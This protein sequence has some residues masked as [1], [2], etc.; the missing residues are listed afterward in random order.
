MRGRNS[1]AAARLLMPKKVTSR[2]APLM[3]T[4]REVAA[5]GRYI[6][7]KQV[8]E[9]ME[10]DGQGGFSLKLWASATERDEIDRL[11]AKVRAPLR[12]RRR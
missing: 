2:T 4:A 9:R 5:S 8:C 1:S 10:R 3:R 6:G 12:R 7:F 11:C